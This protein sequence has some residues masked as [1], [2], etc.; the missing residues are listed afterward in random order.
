[1]PDSSA[2]IDLRDRAPV[3]PNGE[4]S[5]SHPS[6][7]PQGLLHVGATPWRLERRTATGPRFQRAIERC[8]AEA[9]LA[10]R[11]HGAVALG[12]AAGAAR[13]L[14]ASLVLAEDALVR[15]AIPAP[16]P[17]RL[18]TAAAAMAEPSERFE[19]VTLPLPYAA[20]KRRSDRASLFE[21]SLLP[22]GHHDIARRLLFDE[23]RVL[24]S[25]VLLRRLDSGAFEQ[26]ELD[27][28]DELA[29][30]WL[31]RLRRAIARDAQLI[32]P[33]ATLLFDD[34]GRLTEVSPAATRWATDEPI[35]QVRKLLTHGAAIGAP[36]HRQ[37]LV[38][39]A[40][41]DIRALWRG[42]ERTHLVELRPFELLELHPAAALSR[43][44]REV[45][46]LAR[47]GAAAKEIALALGITT[48]TARTHLR[49]VYRVLAVTNRVELRIALDD[50][51]SLNPA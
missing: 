43:R 36:D 48:H 14:L 25:I 1:M 40:I 18:Q 23:Q 10:V 37:H 19:T 26:A 17:R 31:P 27:T 21:A 24:G 45:A 20:R 49:S 42:G 35:E 3:G 12:L 30:S 33:S 11:A 8:L 41:A 28:V 13:P 38:A 2:P 34:R 9:A 44:Q 4:R 7:S 15:A 32:E 6:I 5:G 46:A 22:R 47:N 16:R 51:D 39:G 29:E 50:L